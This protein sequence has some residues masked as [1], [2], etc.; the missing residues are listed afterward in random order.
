MCVDPSGFSRSPERPYL[1][2]VVMPSPIGVADLAAGLLCRQRQLWL[3]VSLAPDHDGPGHPRNLVGERHGRHFR[4]TALHQPAEPGTLLG[5]VLA[6]VANDGHCPDHQQPPQISIALLGDAAEPVLAAGAVLLGHQS[7][8]GSKTAPRCECL[9]VADLSNQGGGA[10]RANAWY[11]R[12]P[13]ACLARA[14]QGQD[15]LV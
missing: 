12:Q 10:D 1:H 6:R 5:A 2:Y 15:A 4:G 3:L 11:F 14:M 8:P 13:P 7:D 9:P